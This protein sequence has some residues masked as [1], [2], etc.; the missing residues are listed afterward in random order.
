MYKLRKT[1]D[2]V[3]PR[4]KL[5]LLDVEVHDVDRN[6]PLSLPQKNGSTLPPSAK[7][8]PSKATPVST[9]ESSNLPNW[10]KNRIY[11]NP[12]F[13]KEPP[14]KKARPNSPPVEKPSIPPNKPAKADLPQK[15]PFPANRP[16]KRPT[17]PVEGRNSP[18]SPHIPV[19]EP[20]VAPGSHAFDIVPSIPPV[21][22]TSAHIPQVFVPNV[23]SIAST[24]IPCLADSL[25]PTISTQ[26]P[27]FTNPPILPPRQFYNPPPQI[28]NETPRL[29]NLPSNNRIFVDGK[30][31]Q[32]R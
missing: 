23:T 9:E 24:T 14:A 6:W 21:V 22:T 25:P 4:G 16:H 17:P 12:N 10:Q 13:V 5:Y 19:M 1:W 15:K 32:V 28:R 30:A 31:Y 20:T 18:R 3:F 7:E 27:S 29:P 2:D 11:V 26:A 8:Q